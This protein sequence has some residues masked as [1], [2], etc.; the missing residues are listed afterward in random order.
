MQTLRD[1]A[2]G[3]VRR[4]REAGF[5][6][7]FAG[8]CVRDQLLGREPQ[9]YDIA[10][11]A[12]PARVQQ[13]FPQ[14]VPI[15]IQFG[16]ILVLQDGT[17]FEVATFRSDGAYLDGRHPVAV[18]FSTAEAD[19]RRRDFTING[20]FF[21]PVGET[22]IDYVGGEADVRA[23][24]VRA[25][26]DPA[27]RLREDRLRMIRAVRFA[28]RFGF[29][30]EARTLAAIRAEAATVTEVAWERIGQELIKILTEGAARRGFELLGSVDLL[31]AVVPEVAALAGVA[32][33]PEYHPEG[34]V[35]VH[36]LLLLEHL[37]AGSTETL[38]LGGLLHDIAKPQCA[39]EREGRITFY[40]HCER[41]AE[42]AL[43]ICRR[44]R[45]SRDV[46][47]RVAYL[48]KNHL[49]LVQAAEMRP[50]TLKRM[51]REEGFLELLELARL[52]ALASNGNLQHVDFCKAK[53]EELGAEAIR[54]EPFVRGR[55]LI[56]MGYE[57]GPNFT[58]MIEAIETAQLDGEVR[59]REDAEAWI[60]AQYPLAG[61]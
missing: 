11:S 57:P 8:G 50:A 51:L 43:E 21:D 39:G 31:R 52:D 33:S 3:V 53:L 30:I 60:R 38:A 14:T 26:G 32:Q 5:E 19:A 17:P 35:L 4:L 54:P 44:L 55:D 2:T 6:A 16:V 48:V 18:Q 41:G 13:L 22:V 24:I 37:P 34:D 10:T 25:I 9:D 45:R 61:R 46:W 59:S 1:K 47:N 27:E 58:K 56:A 23:G 40:G 7:Y 36:T 12:P 29:E 20:L 42:M 49:R 15:G 28:A